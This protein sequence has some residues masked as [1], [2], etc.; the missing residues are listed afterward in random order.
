MCTCIIPARKV[1]VI[2]I[3]IFASVG[4]SDKNNG[5]ESELEGFKLVAFKDTAPALA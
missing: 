4:S 3:I 2:E 1:T 5:F